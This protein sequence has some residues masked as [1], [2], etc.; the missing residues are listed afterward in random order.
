MLIFSKLI[1]QATVTL[2]PVWVFCYTWIMTLLLKTASRTFLSH[3][4]LAKYAAKHWINHSR[5]DYVQKDVEEELK[6]LFDLRKQN[7]AVLV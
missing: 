4:P 1:A 7:L 5:F 3:I 6:W 2:R